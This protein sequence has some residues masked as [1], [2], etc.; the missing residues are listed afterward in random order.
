MVALSSAA[1]AI[2]AFYASTVERA[3]AA[4]VVASSRDASIFETLKRAFDLRTTDPNII[5]NAL[6][7]IFRYRDQ[8]VHPPARFIEPVPHP[9]FG[10]QMEPRFVM[11]RIENAESTRAFVHQI[12]WRCLDKP[13]AAYPE[14][15]EWCEAAK[16][17]I[18]PPPLP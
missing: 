14:L 17:N 10:L 5:R 6:V 7:D 18:Q 9:V 2:D 8:A 15:V 4:K 3:S 16:T 12:I 1:F 11:F 13:N